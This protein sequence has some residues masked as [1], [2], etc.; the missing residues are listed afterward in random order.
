MSQPATIN[1]MS[2]TDTVAP[3]KTIAIIVPLYGFFKDLNVEQLNSESLEVSLDNVKSARHKYNLIFVADGGR[4]LERVRRAIYTK[5]LA[6][7]VR[8]VAVSRFAPYNEYVSEGIK[9]VI[10]ELPNCD[11]VIVVNPWISLGAEDI[12]TMVERV[13][14]LNPGIEGDLIHIISGYGA[15]PFMSDS[16]FQNFK[17]LPALEE[18]GFNYNFWGASRQVMDMVNIDS[19]YKTRYFSQADF[20]GMAHAKGLSVIKSKHLPIYEFDVD[21]KAVESSRDFE[22]DG[23]RFT[24]KWGFIPG[25]V[26]YK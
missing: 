17:F 25:D 4:L 15:N 23:E 3:D 11:F 8:G 24:K 16:N 14:T 12:D 6:G 1:L 9:F 21:W 18:E 10:E 2:A 5:T 22:E 7:N 13:N 19:E 26:N 20:W